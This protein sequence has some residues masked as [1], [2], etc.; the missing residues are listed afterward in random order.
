MFILWFSMGLWSR[1]ES[2]T[3]LTAGTFRYWGSW[4]KLWKLRYWLPGA[5]TC[6]LSKSPLTPGGRAAASKGWGAAAAR[7]GSA[8]ARGR[9]PPVAA[10]P[11]V[12]LLRELLCFIGTLGF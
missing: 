8:A 4:F 1:T 10:A 9:A 6:Y 2:R 5:R 11:T 12:G 7:T 3:S